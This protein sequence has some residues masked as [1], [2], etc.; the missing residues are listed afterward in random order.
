[1]KINLAGYNVDAD[2]LSQAT[3]DNATHTN[4]TPE[5]LSA[6][7]AR[8]SRAPESV[9]VLR[10]KAAK[11]VE[12]ARKSNQNIIFEMGHASVSEHAVFNFDIIDVSRLVIEAIEHAR[13]ASYTEKSQRYIT[14]DREKD[15]FIVPFEIADA[16]YT[17]LFRDF[18]KE[19][20]D[21]YHF[22]LDRIKDQE[23]PQGGSAQEDARYVTTLAVTGQLGM[24]LN[25]RN[26]E[27]MVRRLCG[28]PLYE[29]QQIGEELHTLVKDIAPS[30]VKYCAPDPL[31]K[32]LLDKIRASFS[33]RLQAD[34]RGLD[35]VALLTAPGK[36]G[37]GDT[38]ILATLVH[39]ASQAPFN[40]CHATVSQ[41]TPEMQFILLRELFLDMEVWAA[42]PRQWEM[43]ELS[44]EL[45]C[46]AS[47]FAQ[48]KRH[49]MA[50]I[51]PQAYDP[52]LGFVVPE[53]I[54]KDA[55]ALERFKAVMRASEA[56][57]KKLCRNVNP[58]VAEYALTQ[59]HRRRVLVR[60]NAR[61]L[62][63][64][65]RLREDGHAQWEIRDAAHTMLGYARE[66][67]PLTM[68]LACGKDAFED[69]KKKLF[70]TGQEKLA[71]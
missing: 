49:R 18:V 34:P 56:L 61:E 28:H 57:H 54:Q 60:M 29:A 13:L 70:S 7:Y 27:L 69:L 50:T 26:L 16:G 1:M 31:R 45:I 36:Q 9:D 22:I 4:L 40:V 33:L 24:T 5:V 25:A 8:I 42:A 58:D 2:V 43:T 62:Y 3:S 51:L 21:Q 46:S 44:F 15:E 14:F 38:F 68:A 65:S 48:L 39:Q 23:R 59:S 67:M 11:N 63:A 37:E 66:V 53:S 64:F 47:C 52:S 12:K 55:V 41:M 30:L 20:H 10:R 32:N 17:N 6:A 19:T 71:K 35:H